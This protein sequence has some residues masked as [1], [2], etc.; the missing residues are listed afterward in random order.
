MARY[1]IPPLDPVREWIDLALYAGNSE[2]SGLDWPRL[3]KRMR[4]VGD[5]VRSADDQ[6]L[7]RK[8]SESVG[9]WARVEEKRIA[10]YL[11]PATVRRLVDL[12]PPA[13]G[14]PVQHAA[15][16]ISQHLNEIHAR[17]T[18]Y[19]GTG[20]DLE[21]GL[22]ARNPGLG[23]TVQLWL[24]WVRSPVHAME[25]EHCGTA[26]HPARSDARFCSSACRTASKRVRVE[27]TIS[28]GQAKARG[29]KLAPK[30]GSSE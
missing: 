4:S 29:R 14:D 21:F 6:A 11:P 7:L 10:E 26:F 5:W 9:L 20:G 1:L 18:C 24:D 30:V 22:T 8:F 3:Q 23:L 13:A 12:A 17:P 25:C 15:L 16:Y 19:P 28:P 27:A 2:P